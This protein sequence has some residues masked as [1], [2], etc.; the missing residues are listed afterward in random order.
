MPRLTTPAEIDAWLAEGG[1]H[2]GRDIG[3]QAAR[4]AMEA[5]IDDY[6]A[7]G[8]DIAPSAAA[9]AFVREHAFI[10]VLKQANPDDYADFTPILAFKGQGED[11][12]E[13]SR[14]LGAALF[15]VG[16]DTYE[17]GTIL[18]DEHGRFFY[19]HWSGN[20]YLGTGK[21]EALIGL[22]TDSFQ[23]AEDYFV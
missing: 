2:S 18:I 11:I 14:S 13:L 4:E 15:P 5:V 8:V 17:G 21:Y 9:V 1:W 3:E 23:D 7:E 22:M 19:V 6:R 10:K 20:H 12:D 16:W